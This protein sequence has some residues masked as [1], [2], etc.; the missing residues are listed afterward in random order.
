MHD[1]QVLVIERHSNPADYLI[2]GSSEPPAL[3]ESFTFTLPGTNQKISWKTEYRN[4][5]PERNSLGPLLL[6]IVDGMTYLAT[7]PAGC[8][9]YNKWGRP[10]P[11]YILFKYEHE[12]WVRVP[13][14][15]F[16]SELVHV[17]LMGIPDSKSLKSYYTIKQVKEQ[18]RDR[19]IADYAKAILREPVKEGRGI[20]GCLDFNSQQYRSFKAPLPMKPSIKNK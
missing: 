17:N 10:N 12:K 18:M 2:P 1:G 7:G 13:L 20:T 5:L 6:D 16:P 19:N 3:D 8:V 9:A 4:D 15:E 11:P 14:E